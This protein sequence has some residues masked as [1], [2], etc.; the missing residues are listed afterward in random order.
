MINKQTVRFAQTIM[1]A[2]AGV[3]LFSACNVEV[4][5]SRND[6]TQDQ[7]AASAA[8]PSV[9]R[10]ATKAGVSGIYAMWT[11][12]SMIAPA[13]AI[14]PGIG[15]LLEVQTL[16]FANQ[17]NGRNRAAGNRGYEALNLAETVLT[18]LDAATFSS[19]S[20]A[21]MKGKALL[22]GNL[23]FIQGMIYG[24]LARYY[25]RVVE[26]GTKASLTP[27]QARAK[28]IV[29]LER[30]RAAFRDFA[31]Q[32]AT[33]AVPYATAGL[34]L[35]G[36]DKLINSAVGMLQF[37]AGNVSAASVLLD[38]GYMASDAARQATF[39]QDPNGDFIGHD[40]W[41]DFSS[42]GLR[43]S[44]DL[45]NS[46]L[47]GDT[48]R[49]VGTTAATNPRNWFANNNFEYFWPVVANVPFVSWQEVA[50]M[51]AQITTDAAVRAQ[52]VTSVLASF[53][54]SVADAARIVG[55]PAFTNARIARYVYLGK[56]RAPIS[57]NASLRRWEVPDELTR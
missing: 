40:M 49:V 55:D 43:Y 10:G 18:R 15:A 23:L 6:F 8:L 30:A 29:L 33:T 11:L 3:A 21:D 22:R 16:Q 13:E 46:R 50:M 34:I 53:G 42:G 45:I 54:I 28:G 9:A 41:T 4:L 39:R 19:N 32:P 5:Q 37:D 12:A 31:A 25:A 47:P 48:L 35:V 36:D 1:T 7:I 20:V 52:L 57:G 51:R 56:G 26:H 44:P 17:L 14:A 27:D 38:A 2:L 24:N